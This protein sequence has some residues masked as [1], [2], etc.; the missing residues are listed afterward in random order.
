MMDDAQRQERLQ[1]VAALCRLENKNTDQDIAEL[2]AVLSRVATE[3]VTYRFHRCR[4]AG[5]ACYYRNMSP[6]AGTAQ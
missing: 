3:K 2:R 6:V 4:L 1:Q 5:I